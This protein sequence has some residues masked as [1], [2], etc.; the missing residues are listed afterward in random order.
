MSLL[1]EKL[2][3]LGLRQRIVK[4]QSQNRQKRNTTLDLKLQL[5][6]RPVVAGIQNHDLEPESNTKRFSAGIGL[7]LLVSNGRQSL[8]KLL[9]VDYL[10]KFNYRVAAVV[11]LFKTS[12]PVKKSCWPQDQ[13]L[14]DELNHPNL[15][16]NGLILTNGKKIAQI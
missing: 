9:L 1:S 10:V 11:E 16:V 13:S 6:V 2:D 7:P 5:M 14:D 4:T 8:A 15:I 3:G 12:L